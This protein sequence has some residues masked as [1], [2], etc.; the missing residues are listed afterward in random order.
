M[1]DNE[2]LTTDDSGSDIPEVDSSHVSDEEKLLDALGEEN[3]DEEVGGE[4]VGEEETPDVKPVAT[5][6]SDGKFSLKEG[7]KL[8][9]EHIKEIERSFFREGD[10]TKKTQEIAEMK[11]AAQDILAGH[12]EVLKNPQSLRQYFEDKHILSA[13]TRKEMLDY[14]LAAAG[15]PVPT[16]NKFCKWLKDEDIEGPQAPE[17]DPYVQQFGNLNKKL[18]TLET[19]L[20]KFQREQIEAKRQEAYDKEM[21]KMDDNVADALKEYSDVDRKDLLAMMAASDG[22]KTV[23]QLAKD[24]HDRLEARF[25]EF[26]AKKKANRKNTVKPPKGTSVP[27]MSKSPKGWDEAEKM[28]E[29]VY[30]GDLG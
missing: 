7:D 25:N 17:A 26:L 12:D 21:K 29:E 3:A 5:F 16:W 9:S 1:E 11:K 23:K 14:G 19:G 22:T 8:T 28:L 6:D 10:Y 30:G 20:S 18:Q 15:V 2:I 4:E 24:C 27:L 13:F